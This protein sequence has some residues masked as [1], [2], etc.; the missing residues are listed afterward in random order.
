MLSVCQQIP[1]KIYSGQLL[2]SAIFLA[3]LF[4]FFITIHTKVCQK[5]GINLTRI[6][7]ID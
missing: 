1:L 7:H 5:Y 2:L 3:K 4:T 6:P